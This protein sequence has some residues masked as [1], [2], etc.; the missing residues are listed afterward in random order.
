MDTKTEQEFRLHA[1]QE[2]PKE[3]CGLIAI[4]KGRERYFPCENKS[5]SGDN[6]KID[7]EKYVEV[8]DKGEITAVCHSHPDWPSTPSQADR[9]GCEGSELVW[10]IVR[11]DKEDDVVKSK[12][13]TTI[14]PS[15]YEAPLVGREFFHGILD[16]YSIIK[17]WY[18]RERGI[19]LDNF[20]RADGWWNDGSSNL[21]LD[22]FESQGFFDIGTKRK[23]SQECDPE[24]GDVILMQI[25]SKN[26]VPNHAAVYI[27]DGMILHHL[28]GRLSSRDIYGGYFREATRV[29]VRYRGKDE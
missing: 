13:I 27:G 17:D 10:H 5:A 22:N 6:F 11:V 1:E 29:I 12:D 15:G 8:E 26:E 16:C 4:V 20:D 14:E 19:E 25:R 21:Y 23:P 28:H 3:A 2:Y 18:K 9:V 24:V 7:A